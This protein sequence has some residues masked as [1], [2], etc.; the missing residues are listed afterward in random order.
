MKVYIGVGATEGQDLPFLVLEHSLKKLNPLIDLIIEPIYKTKEFKTLSKRLDISYGTV[1]SLQR[2]LVPKIAAGYGADVCMHLD[3]DMI[4]LNPINE[5][6][7]LALSNDRKVILPLPNPSFQQPQ[8][9]AVF[10]C[11]VEEWTINLFE[12]N[13]YRYLEQEIDYIELMRFG[14]AGDSILPCSYKFNSRE[15]VDRETVIFHMTDLYRQPWVN[16]FN[17]LKSVWIAE[18]ESTLD[19]NH[20]A[21]GVL[22]EGVKNRYYLPSLQRYIGT[23]VRFGFLKDAFFL[24]P[25]FNAYTHKKFG[26]LSEKA[27]FSVILK[28]LVALWVNA[29]AYKHK[30]TN[31]RKI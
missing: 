29:I 3:S 22:I 19:A 26:W 6:L 7:N 17:T 16:N 9:T 2:F 4:C 23:K 28:K 25:Q 12:S 15:Y 10:A 8:Q 21:R 13:L 31:Y 14:F 24:P 1:F 27:V 18:L 30:V 5:L 20:D 11:V